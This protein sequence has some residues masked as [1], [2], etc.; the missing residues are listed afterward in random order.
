[1]RQSINKKMVIPEK[2]YDNL[3]KKLIIFIK[4]FRNKVSDYQ[5][6]TALQ[7]YRKISSQIPRFGRGSYLSLNSEGCAFPHFPC[8]SNCN[9][10]A[11][12]YSHFVLSRATG[13]LCHRLFAELISGSRVTAETYV[14]SYKKS[15][16]H[17]KWNYVCVAFCI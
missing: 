3:K 4:K 16:T 5:G 9:F 11:F 2:L 14:D 17:S 8:G 15:T 1:M 7:F 12:F 6:R 10:F 13:S